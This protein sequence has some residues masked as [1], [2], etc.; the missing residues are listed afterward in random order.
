MGENAVHQLE[1]KAR[2][3][4]AILNAEGNKER[5]AWFKLRGKLAEFATRLRLTNPNMTTPLVGHVKEMIGTLDLG[6]KDA[7]SLLR[8][9]MEAFGRIGADGS[10]PVLIKDLILLVADKLGMIP[11]CDSAN[12]RPMA[13]IDGVNFD[14]ENVNCMVSDWI[15]PPSPPYGVVSIV[16]A[17]SSG[18]SYLLNHLFGANFPVMK[19]KLSGW[20][21]TTKGILMSRSMGPSLIIID[22]EG[23]DGRERG[24]DKKFENQAALFALTVSDIMMVNISEQDIGRMEGGGKTLFQTI[25]QER[26]KLPPGLTKM[27]VVLR[28][29]DE[30]TTPDV[31]DDVIAEIKKTWK[32]VHSKSEEATIKFED[33]IEVNVVALPEK[34][35]PDFQTKVT[36]LRNYISNNTINHN[37]GGK[38]PASS[39]T[40]SSKQLWTEIRQNKRLDLPSH[41]VA[42]TKIYCQRIVKEALISLVSHKVRLEAQKSPQDFKKLSDTLLDNIIAKFDKETAMYD[43]ELRK[44]ER[45]SMIEQIKKSHSE[46]S[47]KLIQMMRKRT[48]DQ[49]KTNFAT[50]LQNM[51]ETDDVNYDVDTLVEECRLDFIILCEDLKVFGADYFHNICSELQKD[52]YSHTNYKMLELKE[53]RAKNDMA[54]AAEKSENDIKELMKRLD[55]TAEDAAEQINCLKE[56]QEIEMNRFKEQVEHASEEKRLA[57]EEM[58]RVKENQE[59][60]IM[61]MREQLERQ[62]QMI[63]DMQEQENQRLEEE[64]RKREESKLKWLSQMALDYM[65]EQCSIM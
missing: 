35:M 17:Q 51:Y 47:V 38:V 25:F 42:F 19:K 64:A 60:E 36:Q 20:K 41:K 39:F 63:K 14:E 8:Q 65:E 12:S 4:G 50:N 13:M 46:Y 56:M 30:E 53:K 45:D 16:G 22:V 2:L 7:E 58:N 43:E 57:A 55:D 27:V 37:K 49:F 11:L 54:L 21:Q 28:R 40:Y 48:A 52:L 44:D 61:K 26:T 34:N 15:S 23:F 32:S 6:H 33:Y 10:N 1:E 31:L 18:K 29:C 5:D 9:M 59:M 62:Y 3:L 24:E